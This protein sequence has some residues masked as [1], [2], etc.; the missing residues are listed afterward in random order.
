MR[1][2]RDKPRQVREVL[3]RMSVAQR[4]TVSFVGGPIAGVVLDSQSA[5][6][7]ER[8]DVAWLIVKTHGGKV[9]GRFS[10]TN[11]LRSR[12]VHVSLGEYEIRSRAENAE[13]CRLF[14]VYG[15]EP[16]AVDVTNNVKPC[17]GDDRPLENS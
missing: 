4:I 16:A 15:A 1:G 17:P 8:W 11:L 2:R 9:G 6:E 5:N 12:G 14:L 3:A 7:S 13:E 10:A